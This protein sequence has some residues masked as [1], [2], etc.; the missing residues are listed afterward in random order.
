MV[1][2]HFSATN[3]L[4]PKTHSDQL[5]AEQKHVL[6]FVTC[7]HS[8]HERLLHASKPYHLFLLPRVQVWI[9]PIQLVVHWCREILWHSHLLICNIVAE[10][11]M[12]DAILE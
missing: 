3:F 12:R 7:L 10:E 1:M 8:W 5:H 6:I 11:D 2:L 9:D 4:L